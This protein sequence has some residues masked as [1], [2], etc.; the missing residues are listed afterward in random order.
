MIEAKKILVAVNFE[1]H[2]NVPARWAG[3]LGECLDGEVQIVFVAEPTGFGEEDM[4][5]HLSNCQ[6]SMA[7]EVERLAGLGVE[8]KGEVLSDSGYG[9][10]GTI[11]NHARQWGCDLIVLGTHPRK[12][13][14]KL[15]SS[16]VARKVVEGASCSVLLAKAPPHPAGA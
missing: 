11:L 6:R 12:G 5:E 4:E 14:E 10:A 2:D 7:A 1:E 3:M 8:A 15:F 9:A 16:S 13:F